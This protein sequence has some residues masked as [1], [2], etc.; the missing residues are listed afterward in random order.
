VNLK[1]L[2]TKRFKNWFIYVLV[3]F[4]FFLLQIMPRQVAYLV[5][6]RISLLCYYLIPDARQK[7]RRHLT[8]VFGKE[9]S[10]EQIRQMSKEVFRNLGRNA[11][12]MFRIQKALKKDPYRYVSVR[13]LEH[14]DQALARGKG[15]I[16][17]TGHIGCWELLAGFFSSI[18]YSAAVVGTPLYDPRL[19]AM[20]IKNRTSVGLTN[21]NRDR[22]ARQ[23]LKE[24]HSN[25]ILGI[26]IDQDTK[27]DGVFVDFLGM[28]ALTP[29]G[30]VTLAMKTGASI[31]PMSIHIQPDNRHL[32]EVEAMIP[33]QISNNRQ[34]DRQINTAR[35]SQA[36]ERMLL[37]D[38]TQ[39]VW[40]HERWKTKPGEANK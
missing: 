24:L 35:C 8:L 40:M 19:D 39:W 6:T 27:V 34:L 15:V 31:V 22:G 32:I 21:I 29:V 9:K 5:L 25:H 36:V 33:L 38:P 30:P 28:P 11:T 2:I 18:G 37:K 4:F 14:L 7:T 1:Y 23:I 20:L 16:V 26:L 10:P 12:D 3:R 13:G 17:I